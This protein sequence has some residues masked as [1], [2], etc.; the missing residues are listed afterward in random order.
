MIENGVALL[1]DNLDAK[2]LE[3]GQGLNRYKLGGLGIDLLTK[4]GYCGRFSFPFAHQAITKTYE[5]L[6]VDSDY[7]NH[8]DPTEEL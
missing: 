2:L 5:V 3:K 1:N 6:S 4:L 8:L 7:F